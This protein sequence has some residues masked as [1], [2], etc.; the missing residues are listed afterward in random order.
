MSL[1]E[2]KAGRTGSKIMP[3]KVTISLHGIVN[4]IDQ[5]EKKLTAAHKKAVSNVEK[6]QLEAKIKH[7]KKIRSEVIKD[8]PKSKP[9][10]N[11]VALE[12]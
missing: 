1:A 10:Y 2:K 5:A 4:Q 3:K 12:K 9:A 6:K 7:L 11:I 8:C